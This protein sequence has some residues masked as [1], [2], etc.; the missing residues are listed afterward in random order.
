MIHENDFA[1]TSRHIEKGEEN[2]SPYLIKNRFDGSPSDLMRIGCIRPAMNFMLQNRQRQCA[3]AN[4]LI[5][6]R[7]H[8]KIRPHFLLGLRAHITDG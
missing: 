4:H 1:I 5:V 3:G 8:I 6:E 7:A 2:P